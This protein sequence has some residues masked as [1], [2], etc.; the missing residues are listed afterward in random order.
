[1]PGNYA[2]G[3]HLNNSQPNFRNTNSPLRR[4][5]PHNSAGS[6][7]APYAHYYNAPA[8][9]HASYVSPQPQY[10]NAAFPMPTH[11]PSPTKSLET[12]QIEDDLR[13]VLKIG[14]PGIPSGGMQSPFAA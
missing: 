5:L 10:T 7:P 12:K 6:S 4:E 1:M 8:P 9:Q 11:S 13:R 14:G 2:Y 3:Q